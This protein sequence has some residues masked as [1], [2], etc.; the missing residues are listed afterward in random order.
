MPG[1]Q[2]IM[3][4]VGATT[5]HMRDVC[6]IGLPVSMVSGMLIGAGADFLGVLHSK[7]RDE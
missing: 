5:R 2:E 7:V 1:A 4:I 3:G 6:T